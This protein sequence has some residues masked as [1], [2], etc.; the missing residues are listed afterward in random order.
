MHGQPIMAVSPES[1]SGSS[2]DAPVVQPSAAGAQL[3][4]NSRRPS[5]MEDGRIL[6]FRPQIRVPFGLM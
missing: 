5:A 6:L 2:G 3:G 4:A 1:S